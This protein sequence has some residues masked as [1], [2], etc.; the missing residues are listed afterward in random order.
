MSHRDGLGRLALVC[1]A[2]SAARRSAGLY[3]RVSFVEVEGANDDND[4]L[5]TSVFE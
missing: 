2:Q 4:I 3:R 1:V 5:E